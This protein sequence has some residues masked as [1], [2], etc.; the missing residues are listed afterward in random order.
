[1][2][3]NPFVKSSALYLL[4]TVIGQGATFAGI[5]IFTRLMS[6]ADYGEYS[7]YYAYVS[8]FTVLIGANLHYSLNN[9]YI[10]NSKL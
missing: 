2:N 6:Q 9:A 5:L 8:I 3:K 10:D 1:M 4:A 7:T